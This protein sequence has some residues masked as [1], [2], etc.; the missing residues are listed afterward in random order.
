[1]TD[2]WFM[3]QALAQARAA[4]SEGEFPVGCVI[5]DAHRIL[6]LGRREGTSNGRANETDHAEIVALRRLFESGG[7]ESSGP[8]SVYCTMEPCL[9]CFGAI[10]IAGIHRIVYAYEDVMGGGT[11]CDLS[12]LPSLYSAAPVEVVPHVRRGESLALFKTFF[13]RPDNPYWKDSELARYT[14]AQE[15][16]QE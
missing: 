8:I 16:R 10:L 7:H 14:L 2:D 12:H 13:S 3:T 11:S 1:M 15:L 5:A 4:F 6:A 9:M